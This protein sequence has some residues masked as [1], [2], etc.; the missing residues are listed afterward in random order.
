MEIGGRKAG[1]KQGE[2]RGK[3]TGKT[4]QEFRASGG[5]SALNGMFAVNLPEW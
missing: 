2:N 3:S 5:V 4:G 1:E